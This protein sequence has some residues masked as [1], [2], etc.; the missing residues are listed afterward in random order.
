MFGLVGSNVSDDAA[1]VA[2]RSV[3]DD[4]HRLTRMKQHLTLMTLYPKKYPEPRKNSRM[5]KLW[6][7]Y[8]GSS[9][10]SADPANDCHI[11]WAGGWSSTTYYGMHTVCNRSYDASCTAISY[12]VEGDYTF[13]L[14]FAERTGC[15][16]YA[17]DPSVEHR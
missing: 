16:G 1:L 8:V 15:E 13:E 14:D 6:K 5:W 9:V 17:V 7:L 4:I 12:G 2:L 11:A 10:T 3:G